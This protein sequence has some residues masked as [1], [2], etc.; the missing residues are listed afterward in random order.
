MPRI[1]VIDRELC[2]KEKCGYQCLKICPPVRMGVEAIVVGKDGFPVISELLCT[3]CGLCPKKCPTRAIKIVNLPEE[4]GLLV[5]QYGV[6]SFRLFNAPLPKRGFVV[7]LLGSNGIGKSTAIKLLCNELSP[8]FGVYDRKLSPD[9]FHARI[10]GHPDLQNYFSSVFR[11]LRVSHKP[12]NVDAIPEFFSG[13]VID[14]LKRADERGKLWEGMRLFGLEKVADHE[15]KSLSGGELQH[16]AICAAWL[17]DADIYFFDEP[18][19]YL[20]IE[21]RLRAAQHIKALALSEGKSV[22]VVEHDLAVLDYLSDH[23]HVFYGE[24]GAFGVVSALKGVRNGINEFLE[25]YLKEENVR[26]RP[27]EIRFEVAGAGEEGKAPAA[28]AWS[29]MRKTYPS[30]SFSCEPGEIRK[31]EVVGIIGPNAIG[32][33]TF[34]RLLAGAEKADEGGANTHLRIS[35]KPQ[36]L[37]ADFVG[38]V[39]ELVMTSQLD[40]TLFEE[41]KRRLELEDLMLKEVQH[42]SGGELQR[43]AIA[44]AICRDADVYLLDEPSAF[45]DVE[46]RLHFASLLK[47]LIE[48]TEKTAFV[49]D[50]DLL[51]VDSVAS[52]LMVFEGVSSV[53]GFAAAPVSKRAGMN[54]F[55]SRVGITLRRDKETGRPRVNKPGSQMDAEQKAAGEYYYYS[56][57]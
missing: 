32:K 4:K 33:S 24:K 17:K 14:L 1:A 42:L 23:V 26:F 41:V 52:R 54:R 46:Q 16:L 44:M 20:D 30:F 50:H 51:L 15:V 49:V 47:R 21:Q 55:L 37:K 27:S 29:S 43:V 8:N 19:S 12:Q 36:Y 57:N 11:G 40:Q 22:V 2:T 18:S 48:S 45:L 35:Y 10:R 28:R 31:G 56:R 39:M 9:E 25:G 38:T 34:I 53:R 13:R 7:G 3:G 6:N 5:F